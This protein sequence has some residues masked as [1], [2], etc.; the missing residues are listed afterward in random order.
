[1]RISDEIDAL[2]VMGF[3][4]IL[5]LGSTRLLGSWLV[6]PFLYAL[7]VLVGFAADEGERGLERAREKRNRKGAD[8]VVYNDV[9]RTDIRHLAFGGGIHFCLG[10]P[11]ARVEGQVALAAMAAR[12]NDLELAVDEPEYKENIVLRGVAALPVRFTAR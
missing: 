11:L 9:G 10:A 4:S 12:L 8:L 1:M 7:A 2:E 6:L 3:D 5:Y